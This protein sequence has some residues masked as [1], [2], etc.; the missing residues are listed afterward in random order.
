[1]TRFV[2]A[3][4]LWVVL[5]SAAALIFPPAFLWFKGW[6]ITFGLALIM[7]GMGLTLQW[8]DFRRVLQR[9]RHILLGAA[10]QFI[11]MPLLGLAFA[12]LFALPAP[13]AAG[14]IL[15]CCCPGGTASN[16]IT[17]IGKCDVALSVSLTAT[18]T[19]LAVIATPLLTSLLVG[20]RVE[21]D[22]W[23]LLRSTAGVVLLPVAMGVLARRYAPRITNALLPYSPALAVVLIVLIVGSILGA[24]RDVIFAHGARLFGAVMGAHAAGF[25]LGLIAARALGAS[26]L[27]A[28]TISIEV[29]MQNSG[30][31][32][33]L[34]RA[35]FANPLVA[36]P[37]A[38]SS[39]VHCVFGAAAAA[40][41]AKRR[42]LFPRLR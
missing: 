8:P 25:V 1:M 30:L 22:A 16:V 36:L 14:L 39:L 21:V 7:L 2:N 13:L 17:F 38:I 11:V 12:L 34:A 10:L 35:N 37:C 24:Q 18:S 9:P 27:I 23:G 41:F 5:G 4:P 6:L 15:V 3:F 31:G 33:V 19:L 29:G 26:K 32:V 42:E 28:R 40:W 20:S